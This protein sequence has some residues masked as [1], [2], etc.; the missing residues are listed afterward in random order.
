MGV[1]LIENW[2]CDGCGAK[3]IGA[4]FLPGWNAS[5][6]DSLQPPNGWRSV[7][8]LALC[9]TKCAEIACERES[10]LRAREAGEWVRKKF[11]VEKPRE[12]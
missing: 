6:K 7:L 11:G 9:S 4:E 1:K 12:R 10:S 3:L 2:E 5:E 8:G